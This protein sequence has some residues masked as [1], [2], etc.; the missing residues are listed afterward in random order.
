M[1][2]L[3]GV[4]IGYE[5]GQLGRTAS[6]SDGVVALIVTG[7]A[8]AGKFALGDVIG[9]LYSLDDVIEK[10][11]T[12]SYDTTNV[13]NAHK[14]CKDFYTAAGE[15]AELYLMV[16]GQAITMETILDPTGTT[17]ATKLLNQLQGKINI[18]GVTRMPATYNPTITEGI[19]PDVVTA[20]TKAQLLAIQ[21]QE[22]HRPVQIIVEGRDFQGNVGDARDFRSGTQN[23]VSVILGWDA[24]GSDATLVGLALGRLAR[25]SVQRNIG[26]V[27]DG[28]I[29]LQNAWIGAKRFEEY[30]LSEL[31]ALHGKGY[32]FPRKYMGF[33]GFYWCND[34][35]CTQ[36]TDD[37]AF[38]SRSRVIDKVARITNQVYTGEL[39]KNFIVD[40]ETG[41]LP[42]AI[43]K[44]F[45]TKV[46]RAIR[47][48]MVA[49]GEISGVEI[50]A[51][52]N[53]D[54]IATDNIVLNIK[55]VPTGMGRN[56][57]ITVG[58]SNPN[59]T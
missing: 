13:T 5:N 7:V 27:E 53:Q 46:D 32:I 12:A 44:D 9:P 10:G 37:Y 56:F 42:P 39:N 47:Q 49:F 31:E 20:V 1:G 6:S 30:S 51:D 19:D 21:E 58:F 35:T 38:I 26:C 52:P 23:R 45:Q 2:Q 48:R 3:P 29:G 17:Y 22:N 54:V 36:E 55:A 34:S 24:S 28:D 59:L 33:S 25:I 41:K 14:Q 4:N 18:L 43:I 57:D 11:I 8:V 40:E 15:G 50:I 16:V